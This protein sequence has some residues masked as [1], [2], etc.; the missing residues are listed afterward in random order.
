MYYRIEKIEGIG[1]DRARRMATAGIATTEDLLDLC[2]DADGREIVAEAT[3]LGL[4]EILRWAKMADLMR[5]NGIGPQYAELLAA[6]GVD[7]V[8]ALC[9]RN[10]EKLVEALDRVNAEH[11]LTRATPTVAAVGKWVELARTTEPFIRY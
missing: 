6:A 7:T 11:T 9:R 5:I 8:E 3:G 4:D 2:A 10:A 1:P